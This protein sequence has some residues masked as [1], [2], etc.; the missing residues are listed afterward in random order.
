MR[1]VRP[2]VPSLDQVLAFCAEEPVERVFLED[3]ARRGLGRFS[4]FERDGGRLEALCH[5][6]ANV[7][8]SG[9]G[10]GRFAR[11]AAHGQA[12]MII[13][14]EQAVSDLWA[15]ACG[16]FPQPR[17]DR[18]G[19]PVYELAEPPEPGGTGLR[20]ATPE[21]LALL[22]PASAA[23]HYEE[24][25]IDP[26]RRDPEGFRWRTRA[27]IDE[28]RSWVWLED[29]VILFKAE[30]S[31][32]TPAAVQLQQVWVDP[33]ARRRGHAQRAMRDLCRQL[34]AK[35][36]IVC[37]FVRPENAPALRLYDSIGM[38]RSITYRSLVF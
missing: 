37:L 17:D 32:W 11:A 33:G 28:G 35:T 14:E 5:V 12:R 15:E 36:P 24:I 23:A 18:P 30:A 25:G 13:G 34:L 20:A 27:Q 3:I 29:G 38:T 16:R 21:D 2:V 22:V 6:G 1:T 31:A 8:P 9:A 26:M 10:C 4:A 19:Q 7:V